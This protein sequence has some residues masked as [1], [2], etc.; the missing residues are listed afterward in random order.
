MFSRVLSLALAAGAA[1]AA[2]AAAPAQKPAPPGPPPI[3]LVPAPPAPP[4]P[5]RAQPGE[6]R[7]LSSR[8]RVVSGPDWSDPDIYPARARRLEQ[9]G[10]VGFVLLVGTDGRPRSCTITESS[11]F[12]ELDAGTCRLAMTMRF[13]RPAAETQARLRVVWL[14]APDPMPFEAQ[15]MVA[16]IRFAGGA[17][18]GCALDG[19]GPLFAEWA[20]VACRTFGLEAEYY[21]GGYRHVALRATVVVDLVPDG[22]AVPPPPAGRGRQTAI[23]R[24]AFSVDAAG[25]PGEC[26]TLEDRGFGAPRI[27]HADAC[28]FFLA[29]GFEFVEI[30]PDPE[31]QPRRGTVIVRVLQE[32]PPT[33]PPRR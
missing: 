28:G 25:D 14:L 22:T 2:A 4:A 8:L 30:V 9:Q 10:A 32:L 19:N 15:R 17:V 20:R 23:R 13:D 26:R 33:V 31:A 27:D 11:N 5:P 18:S 6:A 1:A 16:T 29:R 24:T 7:P 12:A 3:R 21:F